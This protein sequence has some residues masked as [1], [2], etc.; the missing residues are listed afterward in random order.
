MG[1]V[2]GARGGM[3]NAYKTVAGLTP[4]NPATGLQ[5]CEY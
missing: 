2:C 3:R 1:E 4:V 5:A